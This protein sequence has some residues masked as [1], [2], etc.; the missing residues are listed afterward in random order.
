A[1]YDTI[2][3]MAQPF[4]MRAILVDGQGNFGSV[5]GD[6][7]AAMRYTEVRMTRIAHEMLSDLDKE[8]VDF[9]ANYDESDH[10]PS[11]L[12][13]RVPNLLANGS[14]GIAVGMATNIPPHNLA[15]VIDACIA[16]IENP[17]IDIAGLMAYV[18][19]PDFPTSGIINGAQGIIDAYQTGRGKIYVRART[20][21]EESDSSET[22]RRIIVTELPYQVNKAKLQEKIAALVKERRIEGI[23]AMRDESDKDGMRVVIELSRGQLPEVVVNNLYRH[24][25]MQTVFGIN[26]VALVDNQP[27]LLN[28]RQIIEAFIRHRREVVTRRTLYDL[29]KARERIH[30]L[31][32]LAIALANIDAI[33]ALIRNAKTPAE[34]KKGLLE[35][36][37]LP[38]VVSDLLE[39]T[40]LTLSRPADLA[41]ELGLTKTG[42]RLS[43][44]Q[45]QAILDLR[46]HRL[47][48]LEQ[49]KVVGEYEEIL[50]KIEDLLDILG[51][52]D[53]LMGVI[54]DELLAL[55]GQFADKRRTEIIDDHRGL[56]PEDLIRAEDVIVTLSHTG[57]V[58]YQFPDTY[59]AQ[60]R[61]GKGKAATTMKE[62]DFVDQLFV[63][64]T[65]DT[66]LCFSNR[67]R[68]YWKKVFELP[69]ASRTARGTP[70]VNLLPLEE[71]ERINALLPIHDFTQPGF[72][73]M[74]TSRGTIKKCTLRDFSRPRSSGIIAIDL[75]EDDN[76]VAAAVTDG[77]QDLM[78]ASSEGKITRFREKAVRATGRGSMGV[79]GMRLPTGERIISLL[80]VNPKSLPLRATTARI[81]DQQAIDPTEEDNQGAL[82]C[83]TALVLTATENGYGKCTP[84]EEYTVKGRGGQGVIA[85]QTSTRNG[86]MVGAL[87]VDENDEVML[88]TNGGKLIRTR[89]NEISVVGR[90]AQGVRLIRLA[91]NE[92]LVGLDRIVEGEN[93]EEGDSEKTD[94]AQTG[95]EEGNNEE[96]PI[97]I[98]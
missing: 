92:K 20:H 86:V 39:R 7:P 3:R 23:T 84:V 53:R 94:E 9:V 41:P 51:N 17:D 13:A 32:G 72:V 24:T 54:R 69:L 62:E 37:W 95:N 83:A 8:T 97:E 34:A 21:V 18:P 45:A 61:G 49:D 76:L 44:I 16:Y 56:D 6:S 65:H 80:I 75:R 47:T 5:D 55:R 98:A 30:I 22:K 67:G 35:Q 12:P 52:P 58:K 38:G 26:M 66:I 31:E 91:K 71:G 82:P 43:P 14:S 57:Y 96:F 2:V 78:L 50:I 77:E 79:R 15:E 74:V 46:L 1:V 93:A 59:R 4:S 27:R 11:V 64:N 28:L 89:T 68:V 40:D 73:V 85:I 70:I 33:I 60:K 81:D 36:V 10:E 42:Y 63:A 88:I 48:G 90:N 29:K 25:Q 87:L 19:G